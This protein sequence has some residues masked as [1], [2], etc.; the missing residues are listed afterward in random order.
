MGLPQRIDRATLAL[1][2]LGIFALVAVISG[3]GSGRIGLLFGSGIVTYALQIGAAAPTP[4]ATELEYG[5]I[6]MFF[7]LSY[8]IHRRMMWA[9]LLAAAFVA[10]DGAFLFVFGGDLGSGMWASIELPYHALVCWWSL[11]S[12]FAMRQW[13][14]NADI[15][16]SVNVELELKHRL[17]AADEPEPPAPRSKAWPDGGRSL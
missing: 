14:T 13:L 15:V 8:A 12:Y 4:V 9:A 5:A 3:G 17:E 7:A 2:V 11:D 6:F 16:R 10:F 1:Y